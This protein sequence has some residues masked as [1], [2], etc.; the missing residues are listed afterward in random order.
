MF[1]FIDNYLLIQY[2][3]RN[4]NR[5]VQENCRDWPM[6]AINGAYLKT[7]HFAHSAMYVNKPRRTK[8]AFKD[9]T[10]WYTW[11]DRQTDM[12]KLP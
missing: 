7:M 3:E 5:N 2:L 1:T 8:N 12:T 4:I 11:G 9:R 6:E 10:N